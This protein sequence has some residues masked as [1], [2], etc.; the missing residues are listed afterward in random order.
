MVTEYAPE[1][2]YLNLILNQYEIKKNISKNATNNAEEI[3]LI[4]QIGLYKLFGQTALLYLNLIIILIL[5]LLEKRALILFLKEN[6]K[7]AGLKLVSS[8]FENIS[9]LQLLLRVGGFIVNSLEKVW[10]YMTIHTISLVN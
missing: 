2:P 10:A 3:L 4:I 6:F 9:A 1:N 7:T 5:L 8:L